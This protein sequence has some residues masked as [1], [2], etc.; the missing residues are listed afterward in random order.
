M[1]YISLTKHLKWSTDE[2]KLI[3]IVFWQVKS[4]NPPRPLNTVPVIL[5]L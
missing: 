5:F 1:Y 3:V 2:T 4:Q